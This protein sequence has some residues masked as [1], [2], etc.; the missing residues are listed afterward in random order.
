MPKPR[1]LDPHLG[2]A[3]KHPNSSECQVHGSTRYFLSSPL[4]RVTRELSAI[5]PSTRHSLKIQLAGK[6]YNL[7]IK[8]CWQENPV[9]GLQV[10][11]SF[12]L[13]RLCV[14][15]FTV[16]T[17]FSSSHGVG[18]FPTPGQPTLSTLPCIRLLF[19]SI[20]LPLLAQE[21][22]GS[23][24]FSLLQIVMFKGI[25]HRLRSD[26]VHKKKK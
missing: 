2:L 11:I 24:H 15:F 9:S 26:A 1:S 6:H 19:D 5:A 18:S 17:A 8:L 13:Q 4:P 7:H 12:T 10:F 14:S 22:A 23:L 16:P 21:S 3:H 20:S 25:I